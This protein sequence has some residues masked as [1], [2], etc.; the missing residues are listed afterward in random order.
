MIKPCAAAPT[1]A[2]ARGST[3]TAASAPRTCRTRSGG[4][5]AR[6]GG[7]SGEQST[8][9]TWSRRRGWTRER[10][11]AGDVARIGEVQHRLS[12]RGLRRSRLCIR[13]RRHCLR[14]RGRPAMSST[15]TAPTTP[16]A[17]AARAA[18]WLST[19]WQWRSCCGCGQSS[20]TARLLLGLNR[21][22]MLIH[23]LQR[24]RPLGRHPL[25]RLLSCRRRRRPLRCRP[26]RRCQLSHLG[27]GELPLPRE[28]SP[29]APCAQLRRLELRLDSRRLERELLCLPRLLLVLGRR[30]TNCGCCGTILLLQRILCA[31][32]LVLV[33]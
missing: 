28:P 4:R 10:R 8:R 2:P 25:R 3:G 32:A 19:A 26:L 30:R 27:R 7:S 33:F 31:C 6:R 5:M 17:R 1:A 24:R 9:C 20:N 29:P 22:H 16:A 21:D 14:A 12:R 23:R 11:C 18:A 15:G 13:H